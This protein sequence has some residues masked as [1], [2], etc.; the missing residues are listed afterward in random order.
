MYLNTLGKNEMYMSVAEI[1][2]TDI[3]V[4][5]RFVIENADEIVDRYYDE[6]CIEQMNLDNLI[7][8]NEPMK[9]R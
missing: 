3:E 9:G 6:H 2:E 4:I 5:K 7:N 1:L 8:G